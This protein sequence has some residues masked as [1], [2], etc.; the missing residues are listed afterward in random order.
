M[1]G[2]R[3]HRRGSKRDENKDCCVKMQ[4][5]FEATSLIR[6]QKCSEKGKKPAH[7]L[8]DWRYGHCSCTVVSMTTQPTAAA[9]KV[10]GT[11]KGLRREE[12]Q[13]TLFQFPRARRENEAEGKEEGMKEGWERKRKRAKK[14]NE[15]EWRNERRREREER[16]CER[17]RERP[18]NTGIVPSVLNLIYHIMTPRTKKTSIFWRNVDVSMENLGILVHNRSGI[19]KSKEIKGRE[20]P[21]V[22]CSSELKMDNVDY[23]VFFFLYS[24]P[25]FH[26]KGDAGLLIS[27][28]D[29]HCKQ[30]HEGEWK[31]KGAQ[32]KWDP[33]GL[34]GFLAIF[35]S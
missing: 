35:S 32:Q 4:H 10:E 25:C 19:K 24:V 7:C 23:K 21:G 27:E 6:W 14:K 13:P 28:I 2:G 20:L 30:C 12:S 16:T 34:A 18:M 31:G 17:G 15:Y 3:K 22:W 8:G 26:V 33:S 29:H 5:P 11:W 1:L 9:A